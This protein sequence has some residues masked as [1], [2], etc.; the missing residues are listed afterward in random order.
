MDNSNKG[1]EG[2]LGDSI[3]GEWCNLGANT[4]GSNIKNNYS[5]VKLWSYDSRSY[6][7]SKL[8][9]FGQVFGDYTRTAVNTKL[10]TGT[11]VG[12]GVNL[13][14]TGFPNK[15]VPSFRWGDNE[16]T[17]IT[18]FIE[19]AKNMRALKGFDFSLQEQAVLKTVFK[20]TQQHRD[21]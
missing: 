13:F 19:T 3:V 11:I 6:K 7:N 17:R 10:N 12:V 21:F 2:Y 5:E 4:T 18:D 20:L 1:H 14:Q 8:V 9:K 15:F 16:E